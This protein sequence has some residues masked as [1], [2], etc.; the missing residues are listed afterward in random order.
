MASILPPTG[1]WDDW[2]FVDCTYL[3]GNTETFGLRINSL[4]TN[5]HLERCV[6]YTPNM[7]SDSNSLATSRQAGIQDTS[8]TFDG[9]FDAI[10]DCIF[11]EVVTDGGGAWFDDQSMFFSSGSSVRLNVTELNAFAIASGNTVDVFDVDVGSYKLLS[12]TTAD[13]SDYSWK[14]YNGLVVRDGDLIG[15][16]SGQTS[17]FLAL[18]AGGSF[19]VLGV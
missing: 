3:S 16:V 6:F 13:R 4:T 14:D 17:Q 9:Q 8:T 15:A 2:V 7:A 10:T 1:T 18:S 19:L 11:H 5:A 12:G